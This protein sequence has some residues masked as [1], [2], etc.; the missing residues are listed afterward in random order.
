MSFAHALRQVQE[1][2]VRL[3]YPLPTP[4][5]VSLVREHTVQL[6]PVQGAVQLQLTQ[7]EVPCELKIE[8]D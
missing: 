2:V 7:F 1:Q 5:Q 6:E 8:L 3:A 4:P